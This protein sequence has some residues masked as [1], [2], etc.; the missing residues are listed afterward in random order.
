MQRSGGP[1]L[2]GFA[3]GAGDTRRPLQDARRRGGFGAGTPHSVPGKGPPGSA[4]GRV[5]AKCHQKPRL[6]RAL[7]QDEVDTGLSAREVVVVGAVQARA[8]MQEG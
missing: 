6:S 8:R 4:R 5:S 3:D 2:R 1:V 7:K